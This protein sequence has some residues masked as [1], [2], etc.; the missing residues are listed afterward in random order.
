MDFTL[1]MQS[2]V[3]LTNDIISP[4]DNVRLS[5]KPGVFC[6]K[7]KTMVEVKKFRTRYTCRYPHAD[8]SVL[9][10]ISGKQKFVQK[11]SICMAML[12]YA[13]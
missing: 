5:T 4:K 11:A 2:Y 8:Y 6:N 3:D 7:D 9:V 13:H 10:C 12:L 1:G